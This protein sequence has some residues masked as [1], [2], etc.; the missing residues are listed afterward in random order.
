MRIEATHTHRLA[1]LLEAR[2]RDRETQYVAFHIRAGRGIEEAKESTVPATPVLI[3]GL[4][5]GCATSR[6]KRRGDGSGELLSKKRPRDQAGQDIR[7]SEEQKPF[8]ILEGSKPVDSREM[9]ILLG[10]PLYIYLLD[11][12][13]NHLGC[14]LISFFQGNEIR[15]MFRHGSESGIE[16]PTSATDAFSAHADNLSVPYGGKRFKQATLR[17]P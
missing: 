3:D 5:N 11:A 17:L 2:H 15:Y 14:L 1:H 8:H 10:R 6:A 12:F 13:Q 9:D 4:R 7:G 16:F